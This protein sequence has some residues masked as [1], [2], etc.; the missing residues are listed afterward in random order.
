MFEGLD[1]CSKA[2]IGDQDIVGEIGG[3][4]E[5]G[6]A[7]SQRLFLRDSFR[8]LKE[9]MLLTCLPWQEERLAPRLSGQH[10]DLDR[11]PG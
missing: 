7:P 6:T 8:Y 3:L 5:D 4:E 2:F 10:P 9:C 11:L 1:D